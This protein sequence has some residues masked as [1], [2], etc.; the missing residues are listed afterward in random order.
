MSLLR[1]ALFR[2]GFSP[3]FSLKR[4]LR[5]AQRKVMSMV[6]ALLKALAGLA[7]VGFVVDLLEEDDE[8]QDEFQSFLDE[9]HG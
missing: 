9:L 7:A 4:G 5:H 3:R 8:L 2:E 1:H 6:C